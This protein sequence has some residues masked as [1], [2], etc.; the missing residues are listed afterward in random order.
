MPA[1]VSKINKDGSVDI[2]V[3]CECGSPITH[4]TSSG[5]HCSNPDCNLEKINDKLE[6]QFEGFLK[7]VGNL[8]E[9]GEKN[10]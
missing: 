1:K 3:T 6:K 7:H 10:G 2:S 5:M 4:T 9:K 8:F